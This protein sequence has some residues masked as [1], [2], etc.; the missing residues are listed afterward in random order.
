MEIEQNRM[1]SIDLVEFYC[2]PPYSMF[3]PSERMLAGNTRIQA[4][5]IQ[6]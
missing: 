2:D 3:G 4:H 6:R 5:G 1:H